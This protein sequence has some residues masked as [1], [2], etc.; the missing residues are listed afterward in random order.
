MACIYHIYA[1]N[2]NTIYIGQ[3][4]SKIGDDERPLEHFS[5]VWGRGWGSPGGGLPGNSSY[6]NE[7]WKKFI[8][9]HSLDEIIIDIYDD[10]TFGIPAKELDRFAR[11]WVTSYR[12]NSLEMQ[13]TRRQGQIDA[14]R[15]NQNIK[16]SNQEKLDLAEILHIY[17]YKFQLGKDVAAMSMGGQNYTSYNTKT[18]ASLNREMSPEAMKTVIDNQYKTSF[19]QMQQ[20]FNEKFKYFLNKEKNSISKNIMDQVT[21]SPDSNLYTIIYENID[22]FLSNHL[23]TIINEMQDRFGHLE[24][25][26]RISWPKDHTKYIDLGTTDGNVNTLIKIITQKITDQRK[27]I[28]AAKTPA[29]AID[30]IEKLLSFNLEWGI[31]ITSFIN[32]K[33]LNNVATTQLISNIK[34]PNHAWDSY[35]Q[36]RLKLKSYHFFRMC[37]N[38]VKKELQGQLGST[39][40][41]TIKKNRIRK[42][43]ENN[44]EESWSIDDGVTVWKIIDVSE[45]STFYL[46][47]WDIYKTKYNI[48]ASFVSAAEW[49]DYCRGMLSVY[50]KNNGT[51]YGSQLTQFDVNHNFWEAGEGVVD[52]VK[53]VLTYEFSDDTNNAIPTFEGINDIIRY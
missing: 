16:L 23:E 40:E 44:E 9:N 38:V 12:D 15:K 27:K 10:E 28:S 13:I 46:K 43:R 5:G 24:D 50:T 32:I 2:D 45:G 21:K 36:E 20:V 22:K 14:V 51:I 31:S 6:E 1:K 48:K 26:Y 17:Y 4:N 25:G 33:P 19:Q 39:V 34:Q 11:D 49:P 3:T 37:A 42:H 29:E 18:G 30:I 7:K 8:R 47:M 35:I 41:E 52:G 53:V